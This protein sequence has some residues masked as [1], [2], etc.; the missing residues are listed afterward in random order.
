[1]PRAVD[2]AID[3]DQPFEAVVEHAIAVRTAELGEL[4]AGSLRDR[5]VATRRLRAVLRFARKPSKRQLRELKR[6][7]RALGLARDLE[8]QVKLLQRLLPDAPAAARPG[9]ERLVGALQAERVRAE[10]LAGAP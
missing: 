4:S 1:M 3:P 7:N 6:A 2:I 9:I 8:V 10:R 5:R